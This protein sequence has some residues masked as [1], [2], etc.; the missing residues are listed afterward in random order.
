MLME[1]A[2]SP[3]SGALD[4]GSAFASKSPLLDD[5]T[6]RKRRAPLTP[7]ELASLR[8]MANRST[9]KVPADDKFRFIAMQLVE[10]DSAGNL[11]LA[12]PGWLWLE[13]EVRKSWRHFQ[14][15]DPFSR[16]GEWCAVGK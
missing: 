10:C 2:N 5:A 8:H 6:E 12:E 7:G 9:D 14:E 1:R 11:V 4:D 13:Q 15:P 16:S 3:V